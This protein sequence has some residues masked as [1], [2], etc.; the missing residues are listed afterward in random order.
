MTKTEVLALL[1]ANTNERGLANW[2][3]LGADTGGLKSY[4]IGLTELRKLAK[5]IGKDHKLALQLWGTKNHD[6]KV[7]GLLIDEPKLITREQAETQV[8]DVDAGLL[9]HV[10]SS[11]DAMLPKT[12][13]AFELANVWMHNKDAVRRRCGFGLLYELS[14]KPKHKEMTDDYCLERIE[15]ID[16][17]I[18]KEECSVRLS[19]ACALMGLGKRN[20]K[21]NRAGIKVAKR[22]GPIDYNSDESNCEPFDVL[23]HL[24]S[25][26]LKEKLGV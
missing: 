6:A 14:K 16:K 24:T 25:D 18:E 9:S 4:G 19:M 5:K 1:K 11:C 7:V 17:A 12:A 20:K 15:H 23:K 3:K 21:L 2:N 13:F 26:Y 10:F 8:E 22:L